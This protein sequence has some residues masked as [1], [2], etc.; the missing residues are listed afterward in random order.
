MKKILLSL[1]LLTLGVTCIAQNFAEDQFDDQSVSVSGSWLDK[2]I[3]YESNCGEL[4]L[5][6]HPDSIL[7]AFKPILW[8]LPS[9]TDISTNAIVQMRVR[10]A[11]SFDIRI[12]MNDGT[13]STN[14]AN[15]KITQTVPAD[16]NNYTTLT[17]TFPA[18]AFTD[19]AVNDAAIERLHIFLDPANADFPGPIYIDF[20]SVGTATGVGNAACKTDID[21]GPAF[22]NG[23]S[24]F[25]EQFDDNNVNNFG[26]NASELDI[27]ESL[28]GET[29]LTMAAAGNLGTFSPIQYTLPSP[30]DMT[31]NAKIV[32]R[33]RATQ[34]VFVRI[35]LKDVSN[36]GTNGANGKITRLINGEVNDWSVVAYEFPTAALTD[37]SVDITQIEKI[38]IFL[39]P[40][41][42]DFP[43][44]IYIDYISFGEPTGVGNATTRTDI[45]ACVF[46]N[47]SSHFEEQFDDNTLNNF[48]SNAAELTMSESAC[49]ETKMQMAPAGNLGTYTP[50]QYFPPSAV[51]MTGN[52]KIVVRYRAATSFDL[53]VD[54]VD[55][56]GN[57][58]NGA[59]G[60]ITRTL[61]A[62][63]NSWNVASFEYFP[64]A[65]A[66]NSVDVTQI[67]QLNIFLDPGVADFPD[68]LYIDY[69]SFGE[70]TGVGDAT[71][72]TDIDAC[73]TG[74]LEDLI[75]ATLDVYPNPASESIRVAYESLNGDVA[76]SITD[77]AGKVVLTQS[78]THTGTSIDVSTLAPGLYILSVVTENGIA[79]T[80]RIIVQ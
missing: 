57:G 41:I 78:G 63:L 61:T 72:R 29:K 21:A 75:N 8:Y 12:D 55:V 53:R 25:E 50:I 42:A 6:M 30:I 77:L 69:I 44:T 27:T 32:L 36:N 5:E 59:N 14:G 43:G 60:G 80:R 34:S 40:G 9:P 76:V 28:C 23:S 13:N 46:G 24:F 79:A 48:G 26:S 15:G 67:D 70:P 11:S 22:G 7:P 56:N 3:A 58:T 16:I 31:G 37:N 33:T 39:D 73:T 54:I 38:N 51:D 2:L 19:N 62:D 4:K 52:V 1:F 65:I 68:S 35:D 64:P 20:V 74:L 45:D 10:S 49:G 17:Y 47:G 18:A 71:S 66:D